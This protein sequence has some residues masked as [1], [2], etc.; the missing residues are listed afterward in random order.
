MMWRGSGYFEDM[1]LSVKKTLVLALGASTLA[2]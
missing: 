1:V 2:A